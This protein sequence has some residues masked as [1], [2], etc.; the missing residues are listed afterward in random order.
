MGEGYIRIIKI[1]FQFVTDL[2][3]TKCRKS[4]DKRSFTKSTNTFRKYL[5]RN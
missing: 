5:G 1:V 2:K 3:K 4:I